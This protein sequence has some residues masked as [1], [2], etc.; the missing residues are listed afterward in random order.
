MAAAQAVEKQGCW[1]LWMWRMSRWMW[2]LL[3][4]RLG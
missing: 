4:R 1:T 2:M 3:R